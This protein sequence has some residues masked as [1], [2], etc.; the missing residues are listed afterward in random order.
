M[1]LCAHKWR[2]YTHQQ[3]DMVLCNCKW[4]NNCHSR[5]IHISLVLHFHNF[6]HMKVDG[7]LR[8]AYCQYSIDNMLQQPANI[9]LFYMLT[10]NWVISSF[11]R[12]LKHLEWCTTIQQEE[13][14]TKS[15]K[16]TRRD[17]VKRRKIWNWTV[18][19]RWTVYTTDRTRWLAE[20]S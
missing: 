4:N 1:L 18:G 5:C 20:A 7:F 8:P 9:L 6:H 12:Y 3:N 2:W 16:E 11:N 13:K 15:A 10:I 17:G 14:Q 19:K